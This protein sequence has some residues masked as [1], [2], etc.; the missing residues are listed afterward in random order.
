VTSTPA[1]EAGPYAA[2]VRVNVKGISGSGKSSFARELAERRGVPFL[3]LD[4]LHHGPNWTQAPAAELQERV[5]AFMAGAPD[6]WVIDGNY[7]SELGSL[8]VDAADTIVWLD[9]PLHVSLRRLWR[10]TLH[11]IRDDVELWSGN[12][13]SWRTAFLSRD[14]LFAWTLRAYLRHRR[15]WPRRYGSHPGL[16]RLRSPAEAA[17]WLESQG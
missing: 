11:R 3:E 15:E 13:E 9:L 1:I 5:R 12:R 16:V 6:G 10:R 14:A 4:G 17:R 8:V 7:E 2:R